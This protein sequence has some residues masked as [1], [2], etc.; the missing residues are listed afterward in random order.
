M[1]ELEI[2][3]KILENCILAVSKIVSEAKIV[4]SKKTVSI[5]S[6]DDG[7]ICLILLS[8]NDDEFEKYHVDEKAEIGVNIDDLHK[9][10][11]RFSDHKNITLTY[12][13][14]EK[15]PQFKIHG[16]NENG[17]KKMNIQMIE[18]GDSSVK[19]EA[20]NKINFTN[21]AIFPTFY[22]KEAIKDSDLFSDT[23]DMNFSEDSINFH[24]L[25]QNGESDCCWDNNDTFEDFEFKETFQNPPVFALTYLK[26]ILFCENL[27]EKIKLSLNQSTPVKIECKFG[28]SSSLKYYLA[29]RVEETEEEQEKE[30]AEA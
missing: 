27:S 7:R 19:P 22:L 21:S 15:S 9:I 13:K 29:P 4:I 12:N 11:N 16:K 6:I 24:A 30:K 20:L 17:N 8:I 14:D 26:K 25:G 3:Q 23:I 1:I 5:E 28:N 18:M 2:N 10:I